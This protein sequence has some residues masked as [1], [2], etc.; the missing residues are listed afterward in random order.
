MPDSSFF[1]P[2]IPRPETHADDIV[3]EGV[4]VDR[5]FNHRLWERLNDVQLG[6]NAV[7][8]DGHFAGHLQ[9]G[10]SVLLVDI[11]GWS[12]EDGYKHVLIGTLDSFGYHEGAWYN[13]SPDEKDINL[14]VVPDPLYRHLADSIA[15]QAIDEHWRGKPELLKSQDGTRFTIEGEVTPDEKYLDNKW[16]PARPGGQSPL[17]GRKIGMYGPWVRDWSHD[18]R[19]EIH[20]AE[21][22]WFRNR[23][24]NSLL[25]G[26]PNNRLVRWHAIVL[27]DDSER[28]S[29]LNN[30]WP[31]PG[32]PPDPVFVRA[33][34][35]W[36][37]RARL[38]FALLGKRGET[39]DYDLNLEDGNHV[40][41]WHGEEGSLKLTSTQDDAVVTVTKSNARPAELKVRLGRLREDPNDRERMRCF[42]SVDV[43]VGLDDNGREGF[44]ELS[45]VARGPGYAPGVE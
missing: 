10:K 37:R 15:Q 27:Q 23:S 39:I 20:P 17:V 13:D 21:V 36:P 1:R 12:A 7:D 24:T 31:L 8:P 2:S 33:W 44:A 45:L 41:A 43:Q 6:V 19:P 26:T 29:T 32:R 34:A 30:F 16:F 14:H 11:G 5:E 38:T 40:G 18:G 3:M 4:F 22:I 9:A 42:M 28:F 35:A 25:D